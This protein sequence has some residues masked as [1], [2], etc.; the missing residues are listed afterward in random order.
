MPFELYTVF[1]F[2]IMGKLYL[3]YEVV[4]MNCYKYN[5]DL[6]YSPSDGGSVTWHEP[7][8]AWTTS[9]PAELLPPG[10]IQVYD[11]SSVTLNWN[12]SLTLGLVFGAIKFNSDGIV[13]IQGDGSAGPLTAQFQ[14][15]FNVSSTS[16]RASLFISPVTV[17]DDKSLG[18]FRCELIDS[19]ATTWKRAIQVQVIG[20]FKT[21]DDY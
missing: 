14:K 20:K 12:Y 11:G 10:I 9:D 8:P 1:K 2:K 16:G 19:T 7:T 3:V 18:E 6:K 17:A 4:S 13:I 15:R 21:V 5:C